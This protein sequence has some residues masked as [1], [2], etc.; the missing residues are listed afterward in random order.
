AIILI[1]T[2]IFLFFGVTGGSMMMVHNDEEAATKLYDEFQIEAAD[3]E[4]IEIPEFDVFLDTLRTGG[5]TII[6]IVAVAVIGGIIAIF[7]LKGNKYPKPA[8]ILLLVIGAFIGFLQ[9]GI[10]MFGGL[11]Y[12]IA[13]LMALLKKPKY[14]PGS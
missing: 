8:G 12:V 7:L 3:D 5:I 6:V 2:M 9:F 10:A 13:G 11:S 14:E 1:G 4:E